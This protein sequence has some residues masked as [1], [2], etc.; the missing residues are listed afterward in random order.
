MSERLQVVVITVA[1]FVAGLLVGIWTQRARP[2]PPPPIPLMGEFGP[3]PPGAL[4]PPWLL[5][6]G[7][8]PPPSPRQMRERIAALKPQIAVFRK[9]VDSIEDDFRAR[10]DAILTADQRH[11]LD[12]LRA[13]VPH[14]PG[15]MPG[16]AGEAGNPFIPM[17]IYRPMLERLTEVLALD[18]KQH[19]QLKQALIGRRERLLALVDR[20]PPPSFQFGRIF[21][22]GGKPPPP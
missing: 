7:Q 1:V 3:P 8:G 17:V 19:N 13:S 2:M 20:M 5:G 15:P 18:E 12:G 9:N 21:R 14:P 4:P 22:E 11:K 16:C 6:F 10:L